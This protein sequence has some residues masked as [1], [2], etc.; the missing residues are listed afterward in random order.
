VRFSIAFMLALWAAVPFWESRAQTLTNAAAILEL[1]GE[2]ADK[3]LPA[4]IKG[5]VTC[6]DS[7]ASLF[8]VQD[9]SGGIYAWISTN[10]PPIGTQVEIKGTTSK[11][12]FSPIILGESMKTIG[13]VPLPPAR[14]MAVEQMGTGRLDSQWVELEGVVL[15]QYEHWGHL[16]LT[17]GSGSSQVDVRILQADRAHPP[18][19]VDARVKVKGVAGTAYNDRGQFTGFH[20]LTQNESLVTVLERAPDDPFAAQLRLS[21]NMLSYSRRGASEHRMKLRGVVTFYWP[22]RDFYIR[23]DA[24]GVRVHS[25]QTT[26]LKPGDVVEA[27]GFPTPGMVRPALLESVYRK[28]GDGKE[29]S[30]RTINFKDGLSGDSEGEIVD[31]E[32]TVVQRTETHS[33]YTAVV[34][35]SGPHVFRAC[36]LPAWK[37]DKKN[38][39][40]GAKLRVAGICALDAAPQNASETFS[41]WMRGPQDLTVISLPAAWRQKQMLYGMGIMCALVVLGG[42]WVGLLRVR[43]RRQTQAIRDREKGLEERFRDLFENSNDIIYAHD[44]QGE[45]TSMNNSGQVLLGYTLGEL[46]RMNI[47][48]LVDPGD[49]E[50]ARAQTRAKLEGSSRTAYELRLRTKTGQGITIEVNSR[51]AYV[52]G[53]AK[54]V[55]G[56]ARDITARKKAEEALRLSERQLRASLE[57]RER[58]GRDLHDGIIQS[59]YAAGLNLDDCAR[60]VTKDPEGVGMRMRKIMGDLN[61]VIRDVR[62]FIVGLE[63]HRL[64]GSEFQA[65]LKS[66]A[67]TIG[68]SHSSRIELQID[69]DAAA[70]L[71][72]EEATQLLHIAREALSNSVRHA[73][74]QKVIFQMNRTE[75]GLKFEISDDGIGFNPAACEGKGFGLRNMATRARELKADYKVVS[76][77]GEGTRIVLDIVRETFK[78]SVH[79]N[80][81]A[82]R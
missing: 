5:V 82:H 29:P 65:A 34:L 46:T 43:V 3:R 23:D 9:Q 80:S 31:V 57:E 41:I 21:K 52:D 75:N 22:G 68:E 7:L 64:R 12:R 67:L 11:G 73:Q 74:A 61:H 81:V 51:L 8:F 2:N 55:Q 1:S 54:G 71:E 42:G 6:S 53:V 48:D 17:L 28:V 77:N 18:N 63:R 10:Y 37:I 47:T 4:S 16:V 15:R 40:I 79:E 70:E 78:Q 44:L 72:G 19:W 38:M 24:G 45:I 58:L 62:N 30:A 59:I 39:M 36:Y 69:D 26:A 49:L 35:E 13:T 25:R 60:I 56:I 50:M 33:G 14:P 32:G 20:L 27:V 66:L 76:Q